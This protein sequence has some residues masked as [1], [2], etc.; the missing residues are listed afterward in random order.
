MQAL[1][2]ALVILVVGVVAADQ[3]VPGPPP[4]LEVRQP[5]LAMDQAQVQPVGYLPLIY[6]PPE[7]PPW[8]DTENR[9]ESRN[10]YLTEYLASEGA[11]SQWT[12]EHS[13]CDPG[14][15]SPAFRQAVLRRINYFRAMAGIPAVT[16]LNSEYSG[17]AQAAA[18]MMSVNRAL[19]HTPPT[20]WDCYSEA[21]REG[22]GNSNLYLGVYGPAAISG[23]I[24]DPGDGNFPVGH[25]RWILYPQ[26]HYMGSGDVPPRDGFWPSNALWVFDLDNMWGPRP[27]TRDGYVAWPPPGYVPYQV[28]YP[29]WSFAYPSADFSNAWVSVTRDGQPLSLNVRDT[30]NGYGENTLVWEPD[31]SFGD[32]P[33]ADTVYHVTVGNVSIPGSS[34]PI[35]YEVIIFDPSG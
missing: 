16:G 17:K 20:S 28:V 22:A 30:V 7:P 10:H 3:P 35:E 24:Y 33:A 29:R 6:S 19:D 26:T 9:A 23:Y 21:G 11:D 15:T 18:L 2:A 4:R 25:R 31:E 1:L 12:G 5:G 14:A 8:V 34:Q 13:T 27:D 32:R